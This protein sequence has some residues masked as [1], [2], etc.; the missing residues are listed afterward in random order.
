MTEEK[1][2]YIL[3]VLALASS[4]YERRNSTNLE[5]IAA[6]KSIADRY[7]ALRCGMCFEDAAQQARLEF[8]VTQ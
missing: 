5:A 8:L 3:N 2:A 1:A 6:A 4:S 7:S